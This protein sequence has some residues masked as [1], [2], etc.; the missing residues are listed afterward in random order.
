MELASILLLQRSPLEPEFL[1]AIKVL[2]NL[3]KFPSIPAFP[4]AITKS[5]NHQG[6]YRGASR[7]SHPIVIEI[8]IYG[9]YPALTLIHEVA[10]MLDHMALN[11]SKMDFG[12]ESDPLFGEITKA[13]LRSDV[14]RKAKAAYQKRKLTPSTQA[15]V[16]HQL[17]LTG[18]DHCPLHETAR[19]LLR[20]L[21][22]RSQFL[23]D[24]NRQKLNLDGFGSFYWENDDFEPIIA[25]IDSIFRERRLL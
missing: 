2:D 18:F 7:P 12:S 20:D 8:S 13:W 9:T 21:L 10:H 4:V 16:R 25:H 3:L 14:F 17:N 6:E 5:R 19:P 11:P 22:L 23:S 15:Y 24:H 1:H